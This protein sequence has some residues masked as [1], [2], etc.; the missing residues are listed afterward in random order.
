MDTERGNTKQGTTGTPAGPAASDMARRVDAFDWASTPLGPR[1]DW[2]PELKTFVSHILESGF[3]AAIVWGEG[4]V[5]IY[6]DAFRPI[7]G[8]KPEALGRSFA[9]I[10]AEA[11][12]D[13]GPIA[14]RAFAGEATYIE[15][16]PLVVNRSGA[17][18]QAWFTFCYS[19]LRLADGRVA[20]MMDTVVE[21]TATMIARADLAIVNQELSHRLK[22]TLTLVQSIAIQTLKGIEPR[23]A[24]TAFEARLA[25][26]GRAHD[27]LVSE[28]GSGLR[29]DQ[30]AERTLAPLDGLS[31]VDLGGPAIET[32][33]RSTLTLSLMLHELATNSAK[34]GAMSV[35]DGRVALNWTV[36][37]GDLILR[38]REHGG[39]AVSAPRHRGFGSHLIDRGFGSRSTVNRHFH[40]EGLELE[41]LVPVQELAN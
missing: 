15:N 37:D 30:V 33:S 21:T 32:G 23:E 7:L 1:V 34:Y 8:D 20:G 2:P 25:A 28:G 38:W 18:E 24:L 3:P 9:E 41:L 40:P 31:Q 12:D 14:R 26:L 39:P 35:P 11:W 27:V 5:T 29:I 6:N 4:L 22:N 13:I 19:P 16:Y 17:P 10:W 36:R